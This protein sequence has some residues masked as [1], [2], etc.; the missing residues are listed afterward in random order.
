VP[1]AGELTS[2][3][4]GPRAHVFRPFLRQNEDLKQNAVVG[5]HT[6]KRRCGLENFAATV[7]EGRL[8]SVEA[9]ETKRSFTPL[10]VVRDAIRAVD[11]YVHALGAKEVVRYVNKLNGTISHANLSLGDTAFSITEE[12]RG[13]NSDAPPS[14]GGSPVMLQLRIDDVGTLLGNMCAGGASIVFPLQ[15][16]CGERMARVRDPFGHLWILSQQI[17]VL[18]PE[19]NQRRRDAL[20]AELGAM[21]VS[22]RV[23]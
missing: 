21:K 19:E 14:L 15:E 8:A 1:T 20:F 5:V 17:E 6:P 2:Q 3:E 22:E 4:P 13:W 9:M 10:L 23:R 18:T 11:F 12:A 7:A 16:F